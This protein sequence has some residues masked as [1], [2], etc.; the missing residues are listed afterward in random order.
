MTYDL[1]QRIKDEEHLRLLKIGYYVYAAL[2]AIGALAPLIHIGIGSVIIGGGFGMDESAPKIVGA[3]F[4]MLGL[5]LMIVLAVFAWLFY[6]A[7]K[8]IGERRGRIF[9]YVVA[10]IACLNIPVGTI[11]GVF[12]FIVL[13]RPSVVA[14]YDGAP[15]MPPHV[16]HAMQ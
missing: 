15:P 11:L 13:S 3:L 7:G 4:V 14:L 12:T 16:N 2:M 6:L 1:T 9:C 10:V 8:Y 5:G